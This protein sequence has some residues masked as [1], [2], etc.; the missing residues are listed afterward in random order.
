M[1]VHSVG[2][3]TGV[4]RLVA[5]DPWVARP[6]DRNIRGP[7]GTHAATRDTP[8]ASYYWG[9]WVKAQPPT[10]ASLGVSTVTTL[11][12]E[13]SV[14]PQHMP[15][16]AHVPLVRDDTQAILCVAVVMIME[17]RRRQPQGTVAG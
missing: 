4:D 8:G 16:C 7:P 11:Y 3:S 13:S 6:L 14:L 15:L 9:S 2:P 10:A 5:A 1:A 12:T 17:D